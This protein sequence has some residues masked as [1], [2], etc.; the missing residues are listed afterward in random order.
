MTK[1]P[2]VQ[3]SN[4]TDGA[5]ADYGEARDL[6]KSAAYE[7]LLQHAQAFRPITDTERDALTDWLVENHYGTGY[8][9]SRD[10][11]EHSVETGTITAIEGYVSGSPGYSGTLILAI[12]GYPET[13]TLYTFDE[14]TETVTEVTREA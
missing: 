1:R 7:E 12:F 11:A 6:D 8:D 14:E 13:Y 10:H 3:I 2:N 5:V 4:Q 9:D